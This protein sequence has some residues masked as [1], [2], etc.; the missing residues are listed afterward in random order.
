MNLGQLARDSFR[1]AGQE[2]GYKVVT[3]PLNGISQDQ[4]REE[5]AKAGLPID[6][7]GRFVQWQDR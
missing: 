7:Q 4:I 3:P 2:L 5:L 6:R 1:L